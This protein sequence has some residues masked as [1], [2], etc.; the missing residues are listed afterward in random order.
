MQAIKSLVSQECANFENSITCTLCNSKCHQYYSNKI[1]CKWFLCAV[2]P[3]NKQLHESVK[4]REPH[5][6][7]YT[8]KTSNT[9]SCGHCG[10]LFKTN[11]AAKYCSDTCRK[12]VRRTSVRRA[13]SRH[14]EQNPKM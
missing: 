13:V 11:T 3:L 8:T 6:F 10:T 7:P 1:I 12:A 5:L 14:R 2:L 4:Q 9:K